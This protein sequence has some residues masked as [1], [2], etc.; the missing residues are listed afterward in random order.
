[1][2]AVRPRVDLRLL[3]SAAVAWGAGACLVL[4]PLDAVRLVAACGAAAL[5]LGAFVLVAC[6]GRA[7]SRVLPGVVL[8]VVVGLAVL[9][10]GASQRVAAAPAGVVRAAQA[11]E[12]VD[13]VGRVATPPRP[14]GGG[15]GARRVAVTVAADAVRSARTGELLG[16]RVHVEVLVPAASSADPGE[17]AQPAL[18]AGVRI[19]VRGRASVRPTG[20]RAAVAVAARGAPRLLDGAPA[21][22][23]W[24]VAARE[25]AR[26]L[27]AALPGDAGA[28]LPG[29]TVGDTGAVPVDL[30]DAMRTS[31]LAHLT[32]VSGAHF[33]LLG[34]LA[35]AATGALG[36]PRVVR[37][38]AVGLVGTALVLVVG[39]EPSVVRAAVM[40]AVGLVG[41]LAGRRSLGPPAL[42]TAVL[43]LLV[44]D[45]WLAVAPGFVLSV[46]AT[47]GLVV[48]GPPLVARWAP[49]CGHATA[50]VLVAPVAAQLGC[51]PVVLA[52][53]P[54]LGLWSVPAN[55]LAAPVVAPATVL[56]LGA[57]AL[58][59]WWPAGAGA[60]A[61]VAG[62][63][64][65]WTGAVARVCAGLPG[66]AVPWLPGPVG[67][68]CAL[69]VAV[70]AA[71][72]LAGRAQRG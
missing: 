54:S 3:P 23:A 46:G 32:A 27:A 29:V 12:L 4:V 28:L 11:G 49:R 33:A 9:G 21:G 37:A 19:A 59:G 39:P 66:A 15:A 38:A 52:L 10:A 64:C 63:A 47:A 72:L 61:A 69:L 13:V 26:E 55:L 41:L 2:S 60:L 67:A 53:W 25:H 56:G 14:L 50:G 51:L 70:A 48:V 58:A 40:G 1:M 17:V 22:S 18:D 20:E 31:G 43:V 68:G 45:P 7:R 71:V 34:A 65:W 42:C 57:V 16:V 35:L 24:S 44:H 62:A 6:T 36:A 8:V 30:R 5:V